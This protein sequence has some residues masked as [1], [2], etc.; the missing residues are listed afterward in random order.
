M[1]P[2]W[3]VAGVVVTILVVILIVVLS[4]RS[5]S[6]GGLLGTGTASDGTAAG[7]VQAIG[8]GLVSTA[9]S[10]AQAASR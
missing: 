5:S 1:N 2:K 4:N 6:S 8:G 7:D 10:I 3:V 9:A